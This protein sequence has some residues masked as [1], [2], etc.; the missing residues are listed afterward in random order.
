MDP[1]K[2][3]SYNDPDKRQTN[4]YKRFWELLLRTGVTLNTDPDHDAPYLKG[5]KEGIAEVVA[6]M[7]KEGQPGFSSND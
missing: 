7:K 3:L 6:F 4:F 5:P 1:P 2:K